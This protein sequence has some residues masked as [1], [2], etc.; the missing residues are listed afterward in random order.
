MPF[1]EVDTAE[2]RVR[3][4][5]GGRVRRFLGVRYGEST[6]GQHRFRAPRRLQAWTG[7][8]DALE[9]APSCPQFDGRAFQSSR[10]DDL[11]SLSFPRT[12]SPLEGG[13][14]SED[15]LHL[16]VWAPS[17][18]ESAPVLVWLHGGGYMSGSG[19]EMW[20][21]GDRLA[22]DRDVV[23][24][25]VTH[26][27]GVLGF[28]DL[29][30][31]GFPDSANAGLLDL[32][33]ALEWVQR[34][35]S[36]FGGDPDRVTIAGQS[37]GGGKVTALRA[38]PAAQDLF[39]RSIVMSGPAREVQTRARAELLAGRVLDAFEGS[40]AAAAAAP[41]EALIAAQGPALIDAAELAAGDFTAM[42]TAGFGPTLDDVQLPHHPDV[43]AASDE[44]PLLIGTTTHE[45]G[46]LLLDDP[47]Y[48]IDAGPSS[49]ADALGISE[50]AVRALHAQQ[51]EEPTHL[52]WSRYAS[53]AVFGAPS[54]ELASRTAAPVWMYQF[55]R[56]TEVMGGLLGACHSLD[57][58]YAFGTVDRIPL[59]G[60]DPGRH[61]TSARMTASWSAFVHGDSPGWPAWQPG[62]SAELIE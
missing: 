47:S 32:V 4:H 42:V 17:A 59:T 50:G 38:M 55:D 43:A 58:A 40:A 39:H 22:A 54:R 37:G 15:C 27:L 18:A 61:A 6:A 45:L 52:L 24:V 29:R 53:D 41:V 3:G 23:V 25:T 19:N 35:I 26:R 34:N 33:A 48:A 13:P 60:R 57:L 9:Y 49:V 2:G 16:N 14:T 36:A 8:R 1:V 56:A 12:G 20:V 5:D 31:H 30:L 11:A 28:L 7:V 10:S 62:T 51:P 21:A 46:S 44:R